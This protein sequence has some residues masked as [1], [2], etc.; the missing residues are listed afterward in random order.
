MTINAPRLLAGFGTLTL[1][2][3]IGLFASHPAHTAGGPVPVSVANSPLQTNPV[4]VAAPTQPFQQS[5]QAV[6]NT[7]TSVSQSI[8]VPPHK[9]LVIE[10]I[11]ASLNQYSPG[12]GGYVYLQ[13]V[14]GG[15]KVT[16][17]LTNGIQ[18][19]NKRNQT[20]RIYADP[21]TTVTIGAG[22]NDFST[23]GIGTDTEVSGY[24][25]NVP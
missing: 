25:V 1:L 22:S 19:I 7:D 23:P 15:R 17:Y 20:L 2:A 6:S 10:Y 11:S 9:R 8:T 16:Y 14:A 18:D 13:T 24:Y 12:I 5:F 4:D 3:G 21:G